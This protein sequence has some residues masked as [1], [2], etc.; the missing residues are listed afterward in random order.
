MSGWTNR[1]IHRQINTQMQKQTLTQTGQQTDRRLICFQCRVKCVGHPGVNWQM[2]RQMNT[3]THMQKQIPSQTNRQTRQTDRQTDR[4]TNTDKPTH[5]FLLSSLICC[6]SSLTALEPL[7]A[8][9]ST[10]PITWGNRQ[11]CACPS[12]RISCSA[13][14]SRVWSIMLSCDDKYS[15]DFLPSTC[16]VNCKTVLRAS[17]KTL[18]LSRNLLLM[19]GF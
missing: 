12:P 11:W 14:G 2:H 1:Q 13:S 4:P 6:T 16:K 17:I 5:Y 15:I 10:S 18:V 8:C 7:A 3:Q 9:F 19:D